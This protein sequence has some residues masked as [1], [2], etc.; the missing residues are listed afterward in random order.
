MQT[1]VP[2]GLS[3]AKAGKSVYFQAIVSRLL[4]TRFPAG[5]K[6]Q[7]SEAECGVIN[8]SRPPQLG[9][10]RERRKPECSA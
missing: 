4:L 1:S 2:A 10:V 5:E 8:A 3:L 9:H 7:G 6:L